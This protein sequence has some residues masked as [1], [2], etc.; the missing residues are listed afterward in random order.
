MVEIKTTAALQHPHILPL[1]DSRHR[2]RLPLLRDA[3]HRR[4]DAPRASSIARPSSASTRRCGSRVAVADALDYAHRHG[5]IHRDIKP[6]NILL[7]DGRPMVADFGIALALSAAAG[8]RMTETGMSPRHAALHE[9]RAGHGRE[10]D[11]RPLRHL[12][13]R[14]RALR[15]AHRESA[16]H[17]RLGAA[18]HHEDRDRGGRPGHEAPEVGAA[19]RGGRRGQVAGEA[20]G[21]PVRDREGVR[22]RARQPGVHLARRPARRHAGGRCRGL[23]RAPSPA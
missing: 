18:D 20:A 10:G 15:D 8:G 7:H 14:Q 17:R 3:V 23:P 16:A 12:F 22:R 2:R 19:E 9:P 21:R 5:V 4:R 11:H 13:A 6:E 1:F